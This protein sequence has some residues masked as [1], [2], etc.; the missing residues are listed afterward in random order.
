M[1]GDPISE[2][3]VRCWADEA[4]HEIFVEIKRELLSLADMIQVLRDEWEEHRTAMAID[5]C[6]RLL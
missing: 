3:D 6:K 5:S 4:V 1:G 2:G